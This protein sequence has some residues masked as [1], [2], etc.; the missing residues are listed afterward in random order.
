MKT[1]EIPQYV[2]DRFGDSGEDV[3]LFL[4]VVESKKQQPKKKDESK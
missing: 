3:A 4:T 2:I 1:N